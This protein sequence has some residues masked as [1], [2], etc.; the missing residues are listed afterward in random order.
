M[1]KD[2]NFNYEENGTENRDIKNEEKLGYDENN[3]MQ[4]LMKLPTDE[5]NLL[6]ESKITD[7][8]S[9]TNAIKRRETTHKLFDAYIDYYRDLKRSFTHLC[10]KLDASEKN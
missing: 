3:V 9:S 10:E 8:L 2:Y 1:E 4:A 5:K 7:L 6:L